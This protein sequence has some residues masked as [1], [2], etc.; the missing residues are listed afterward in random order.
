M[1]PGTYRIVNLVS[2]TVITETENGAV[3]WQLTGGKHQQWFA[4]RSGE[5]YQF[6]NVTSGGYLTIASTNDNNNKLYC[7]A[8]P[9]TWMLVTNPEYTGKD[10][11]GIVMGDTDRVLDLNDN[12]FFQTRIQRRPE[13]QNVEIRTYKPS[14]ETGEDPTEAQLA[15]ARAEK[16]IQTQAAEIEFLRKLLLGSRQEYSPKHPNNIE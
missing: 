6:Q 11:Y 9:T 12:D 14:D 10:V 16:T 15:L 4:Q 3:G 1:K 5:G 8:Y 7:G 2:G 13:M